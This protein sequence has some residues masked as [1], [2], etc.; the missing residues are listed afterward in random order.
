MDRIRLTIA[1]VAVLC[2]GTV[3]ARSLMGKSSPPPSLPFPALTNCQQKADSTPFRVSMTVTKA[4]P[5]QTFC[6]N[7][8][9]AT[10]NN[11]ATS[12]G[13]ATKLERVQFWAAYANR[14]G[15]TTITVRDTKGAQK[16]VSGA[17]IKSGNTYNDELVIANLGWTA[18]YIATASPRICLTL[19]A[20]LPLDTLCLGPAGRCTIGLYSTGASSAKCCPVYTVPLS[21]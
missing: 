5:A 4:I 12:C 13:K 8:T 20:D 7:I 19:H 21:A 11:T 10:P 6:F 18:G 2:F 14:T 15:I 1:L 9:T 17:W 3:Q 16:T